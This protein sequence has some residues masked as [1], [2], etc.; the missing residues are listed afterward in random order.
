MHSLFH[1]VKLTVLLLNVVEI[2]NLDHFQLLL[3][4]RLSFFWAKIPVGK[5]KY[6][7]KYPRVP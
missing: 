1:K 6:L 4:Y 3:G 2:L 5:Y 7:L